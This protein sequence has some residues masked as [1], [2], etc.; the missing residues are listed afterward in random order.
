MTRLHAMHAERSV[1]W[2]CAQMLARVLTTLLF[3][4]KVY[5]RENVPAQGGAII[6]SNHQG[7]LDP[8]VLAV[9][10]NRSV[11]YIAKSELFEGRI[12]SW[13]LRTVFN[14]FPVRQG[15]GDV[16]AVRETIHRLREGHLLNLYPEGARSEDGQIGPMLRGVG[17][18]VHRAAVPVVPAVIVGSFEAW[19]I[20]R[21]LFRAKPVRV[22]YG[23][24]MNVADLSPD[25]IT[26]LIDR[27]LRKMF[28][29]LGNGH[30][31]GVV[32]RPISTSQ[33]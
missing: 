11:N 8:V 16:G 20:Q 18:I 15:A 17:L 19:P 25:E 23:P 7:N 29:D 32:G 21:T 12:G 14:A 28:E 31:A 27:T 6:V 9:R 33:R 24:P 26:A 30:A 3:D 13:L 10:L 1:P 5:G 2:R 22:T 4:L